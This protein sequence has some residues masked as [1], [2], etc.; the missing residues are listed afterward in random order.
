V[1]TPSKLCQLAAKI[2]VTV[3]GQFVPLLRQC[4][5]ELAKPHKPC[6]AMKSSTL[7]RSILLLLLLTVLKVPGCGLRNGDPKT[8]GGKEQ[9]MGSSTET[10]DTNHMT[11]DVWLKP[12]VYSLSVHQDSLSMHCS[13]ARFAWGG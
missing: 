7:H 1:K 6:L 3:S 4:S 13:N 12:I 10:S 2:R 11:H 5:S 9:P 8:H